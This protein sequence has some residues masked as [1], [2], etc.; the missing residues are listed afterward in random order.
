VFKLCQLKAFLKEVQIHHVKQG[1][2]QL[3]VYY[4]LW[5]LGLKL[6]ARG[7]NRKWSSAD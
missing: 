7:T 5:L 6:R 1:N 2:K 4:D 3:S